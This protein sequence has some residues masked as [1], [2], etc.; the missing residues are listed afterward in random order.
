MASSAE[1]I[2]ENFPHPTI[3]PIIGQPTH[4]SLAE[5]HLKLNANA[6]SVHSNQGDRQFGHI[7]LTLKPAVYGTLSATPFVPPANPGQNPAVPPGSTAAQISEIRRTHK[8][9]VD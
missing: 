6:V 3:Q 2:V 5:L 9:A 1:K 7:F 4:E 8:E